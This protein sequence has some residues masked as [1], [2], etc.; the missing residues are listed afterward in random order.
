MFDFQREGR[1]TAE[2]HTERQGLSPSAALVFDKQ[3][4]I[5]L[6]KHVE[7]HEIKVRRNKALNKTLSRSKCKLPYIRNW[8]KNTRKNGNYCPVNYS[9]MQ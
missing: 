6:I 5:P 8:R 1:V 4:D 7:Y 2:D 3:K 9:K